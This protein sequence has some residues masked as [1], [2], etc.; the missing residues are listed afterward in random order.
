MAA[1]SQ[2]VAN[3][4]A[5]PALAEPLEVVAAGRWR[6]QVRV[7]PHHLALA[8]VLA[9]SALLNTYRLSQNGYAN[10]F[11]SAGIKS[12][13]RSL[14]N[15]LFVSFDPSGGLSIMISPLGSND[16]NRKLCSERSIDLMPA[17]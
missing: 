14:H 7:M 9:L 12:M 11:Y 16:T 13:L 17:E 1:A 10:I 5:A 8:A 3:A 15:F 4:P 2:P 6:P